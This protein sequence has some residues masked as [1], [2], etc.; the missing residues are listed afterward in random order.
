MPVK[1]YS[2]KELRE[3]TEEAAAHGMQRP[4]SRL[5]ATVEEVERL[6]AFQEKNRQLERRMTALEIHLKRAL[7][8]CEMYECVDEKCTCPGWHVR[9]TEAVKTLLK[10]AKQ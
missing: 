6:R 10:G 4:S 5:V 9:E 1:P 8:I 2:M 3:W 7:K